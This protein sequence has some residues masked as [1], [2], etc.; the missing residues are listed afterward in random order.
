[1]TDEVKAFR[2]LLVPLALIIVFFVITPRVCSRKHPAASEQTQSAAASA[3][4]QGVTGLHIEGAPS[5]PGEAKAST[6]PEGLDAARI[7]YLVEINESFAAP[8]TATLQKTYIDDEITRVL[9]SMGYIEKAPGPDGKVVLTRD[10][11]LNLSLTEQADSWTFPIAKRVFDHVTFVSRVDDDK[12]DGTFTWHFD[13]T[14]VGSALLIDGK[15]TH[16]STARFVGGP[17][18]WTLSTL[19]GSGL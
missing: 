18:G 7:Q 12:Y 10:G 6:Y 15:A 1:M 9:S 8:K 16:S 4:M 3:Q 17:G 13:P 5:S 2:V 11:V 14:A 19:M